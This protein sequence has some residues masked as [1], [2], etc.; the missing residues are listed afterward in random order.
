[1][2]NYLRLHKSARRRISRNREKKNQFE[3][4][5]V[6]DGGN[7]ALACVVIVFAC[8]SG[9]FAVVVEDETGAKVGV[10][11]STKNIAVCDPAPSINAKPSFEAAGTHR[12]ISAKRAFGDTMF[13][14]ARRAIEVVQDERIMRTG[15][16]IYE[17][18]P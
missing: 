14:V 4:I 9:D 15:R 16:A 3:G 11:F 17:A 2:L 13:T 6:L 1:V 5:F 12:F 7:A 8:E 10:V 18:S